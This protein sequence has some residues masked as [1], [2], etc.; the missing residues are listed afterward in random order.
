MIREFLFRA[1]LVA[2]AV[3]VILGG[4]VGWA[5]G[6]FFLGVGIVLAVAVFWLVVGWICQPLFRNR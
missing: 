3:S 1:Y 5:K 6:E 4:G 2:F